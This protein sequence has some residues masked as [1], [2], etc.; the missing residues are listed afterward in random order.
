MLVTPRPSA[1]AGGRG[2]V[3]APMVRPLLTWPGRRAPSLQSSPMARQLSWSDV[4]GGLIACLI[5]AAVTIG[6]LEF[7][8]FGA[9]HGNTFRLYAIVGQARGVLAGSEVWLSGQK[10]GK[11]TDIRFRTPSAD[12]SAR[13]EI[14][15]E[16]LEAHRAAMRADAIAQIR[17]GGSFIGAPVVY[18]SP[19]TAAA[20][21]LQPGDTVHT[22][23]QS[24]VE[25]AAGSFGVATR[26]FPAIMKN[27]RDVATQLSATEGTIGA[28]M[29]TPAGPG[30]AALAQTRVE[31]SRLAARMSS[32]GSVGRFMHGDLTARSAAVLARADSVR[33]LIASPTSSYGRL[34]KDSTLLAEVSDIRN[35]LSNVRVLLDE[36]RGT[37]GRVLHDSAVTNALGETQLEMTRLFG[38]MKKHPLRYIS[39]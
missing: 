1:D 30:G 19:G 20:R 16:V 26:E 13:I 5:L 6:V 34:R 3:L 24:D 8:G 23:P 7:A 31:F 10:I 36:P 15:M 33:I 4:R 18:L 14:T 27:V 9:L 37:A 22:R 21:P 35:E 17:A 11:I 2:A 32:G 39:F 38:D 12:T 28:F 29:H 25:G